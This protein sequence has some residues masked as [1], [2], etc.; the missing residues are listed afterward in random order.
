MRSV[1]ENGTC[2]RSFRRPRRHIPAPMPPWTPALDV[3]SLLDSHEPRRSTMSYASALVLLCVPQAMVCRLGPNVAARPAQMSGVFGWSTGYSCR[4]YTRL[5][6]AS[7]F[8]FSVLELNMGDLVRTRCTRR[9]CVV[10]SRTSEVNRFPDDSHDAPE[11]RDPAT[12][13]TVTIS[14]VTCTAVVAEDC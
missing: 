12:L 4:G 7:V 5:A 11:L 9:R 14:A 3:A 10:D 1:A 13:L 2:I 8:A 6:L